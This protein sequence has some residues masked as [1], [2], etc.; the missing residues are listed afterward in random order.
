VLDE[1]PGLAEWL[2]WAKHGVPIMFIAIR[3]NH[4]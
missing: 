2:G 4:G 3:V 1:L